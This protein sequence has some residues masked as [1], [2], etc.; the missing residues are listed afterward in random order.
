MQIQEFRSNGKL[1]LTGEYLVLKGAKA[2]AL[3]L[4][5]GQTLQV[6]PNKTDKLNWISTEKGTPFFSA[7]YRTNNLEIIE[8]SDEIR[9]AYIQQ[10]LREAKLLN[11]NFLNAGQAYK[12]KANIEFNKLW[13]LGSSSTLINNLAQWAGVDA[14]TLN[15]QISK[16]S[17]YDIACAQQ[18]KPLV[19]QLQN[20]KPHI[21]TVH[22]NPPFLKQLNLVY[23]NQ[24]MPTETNIGRFLKNNTVPES[25]IKSIN[26]LTEA[27]LVCTEMSKFQRLMQEHEDILANLLQVPTVKE[28]HFSDF[29]GT[30]KSLGA[31][32]G[33]FILSISDES[34]EEQQ[35]Y[36]SRRGFKTILPLAPLL[37]V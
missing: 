3:P 18:A 6:E 30:L 8:S 26:L 12:I 5:P 11:P 2:L 25:L 16:G 28:Q 13:G 36:F 15:Q 35:N 10:L 7:S 32:G 22:F 20:N 24:K 34:F 4:K 29:K 19:Y 33:D 14:F 17:G 37:C 31:W 21:E 1:L 9:G 27:V 23:L